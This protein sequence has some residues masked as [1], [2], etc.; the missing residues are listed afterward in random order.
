[1][2]KEIFNYTKSIKFTSSLHKTEKQTNEQ[3]KIDTC[4]VLRNFIF[5]FFLSHNKLTNDTP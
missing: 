3:R 4:R 1:M 2:F 5:Y